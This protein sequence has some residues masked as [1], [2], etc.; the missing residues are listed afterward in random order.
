MKNTNGYVIFIILFSVAVLIVSIFNIIHYEKILDTKDDRETGLSR[1]TVRAF[2]WLNIIVAS[3]AGYIFLYYT[4][5]AFFGFDDTYKKLKK[6]IPSYF[7]K[8]SKEIYVE[9]I[10]MGYSPVESTQIASFIATQD[11]IKEGKN[12]SE[13][14]RIGKIA[15]TEVGVNY[16]YSK[17][18][19]KLLS[20]LAAEKAVSKVLEGYKK[21]QPKPKKEV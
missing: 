2:F 21:P 18:D 11:A 19:A 10:Q 17:D 5:T 14:V 12:L 9:S 1:G 4:F 20:K 6:L 13:A 7:K 16:G 15:G 3:I 8:K